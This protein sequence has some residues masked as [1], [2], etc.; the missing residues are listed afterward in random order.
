MIRR[1]A[2]VFIGAALAA[3]AQTDWRFSHPDAD[4]RASVNLQALM[5][6]PVVQQALKQVEEKGGQNANQVKFAVNLLSSIDRVSISAKQKPGAVK[7]AA[8]AS[9]AADADVLILI[10]GSFDPQT[11][12][13]LVP[14]NGNMQ[15]QVAG[16]NSLLI[17]ERASLNGA[18][19]RLGSKASGPAFGEL[20][21]SDLWFWGGPGLFKTT[22]QPPPEFKSLR[23]FSM[24]MN[25]TESPEANLILTAANT[26][27][28]SE[29]LTAVH[30]LIQKSAD[31]PEKMALLDKALTTTQEGS[32]VRFRWVTPPELMQAMKAA[33]EQAASGQLGGEVPP[34]LQGLLSLFGVGGGPAAAAPAA[35]QP[36]PPANGGKIVIY[37]LEDGPHE[38]KP[39][40]KP[41]S[42]VKLPAN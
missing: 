3:Q 31:S 16:Q 42:V 5:K 24:G 20:E 7:P 27:G 19:A 1:I 22:A 13:A 12:K 14:A 37:G 30:E 38:V 21:Q 4:F 33:Q 26:A 28:A 18:V 6:S 36:K 32:Q 29:I 23:G 2:T 39:Q 9:P 15:I 11:I 17:G 10:S 34:Q 8:N 35:A 41:P 40:D 25:L